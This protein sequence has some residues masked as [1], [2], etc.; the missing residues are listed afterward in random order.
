M[1]DVLLNLNQANTAIQVDPGL[2]ASEKQQLEKEEA[3]REIEKFLSGASGAALGV[4]IAKYLKLGKTLQVL[5]GA[6]GYGAGRMVFNA[7]KAS[8]YNSAAGAYQIDSK[9]Y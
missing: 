1:E 3:Q 8:H 7:I 6:L 9:R 5:L 2:A 4:V